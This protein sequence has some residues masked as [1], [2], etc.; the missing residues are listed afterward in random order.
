MSIRDAFVATI[1]CNNESDCYDKVQVIADSPWSANY[2][3]RLLAGYDGWGHW[4][5]TNGGVF[6]HCPMH[7]TDA[8]CTVDCAPDCLGAAFDH[9]R[10][11]DRM[12]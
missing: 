9:A 7:R 8:D 10:R 12:R 5:G 1:V 2:D 4:K 11:S 3:V 6:H